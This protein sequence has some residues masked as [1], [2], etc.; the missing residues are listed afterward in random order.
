MFNTI[1]ELKEFY[2]NNYLTFTSK[3]KIKFIK[4]IYK[5]A[6]NKGLTDYRRIF[7][8]VK[9]SSTVMDSEF[10]N[11]LLDRLTEKPT[12][13]IGI[14]TGYTTETLGQKIKLNERF[15]LHIESSVFFS[16]LIHSN[17]IPEVLNIL[18]IIEEVISRD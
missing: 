5:L 7:E 9:K 2:N 17:T 18:E 1:Q 10:I 3:D 14:F 12:T 4:E 16:G 11:M 13:I 8:S 15:D 6:N